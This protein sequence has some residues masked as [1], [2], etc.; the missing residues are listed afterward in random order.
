MIKFWIF[1]GTRISVERMKCFKYFISSIFNLSKLL[2]IDLMPIVFEIPKDKLIIIRGKEDKFI[3]DNKITNEL[4]AKGI[5]VIEIEGVGHSWSEK[6][7]EE[8]DKIIK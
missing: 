1:E 5:N 4:K 6:I 3:F 7:N 2:K 8:I